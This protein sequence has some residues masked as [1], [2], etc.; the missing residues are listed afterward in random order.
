[1]IKKILLALF[2]TLIFAFP[3]N[4]VAR[5]NVDY[6]YIKDFQ[7]EIVVNKDS[8]ADVT[9]NIV[10][11]CG[12]A[13][14]HGIFRVLPTFQQLTESEKIQTPVTLKSITDFNDRPIKYSTSK[15]SPDGTITWKI[16]DANKTVS[17]VNNYRIKYHIKNAVRHNSNDFDE[18]YWNLSGNFWD[19][20]IDNF[21][22]TIIF[23]E[24]IT[25]ENSISTV[26]SG[27]FGDKNSLG[28]TY[29]WIEKN[30]LQVG[31]FGTMQ[32]GE[33]I[34]LS[35]TFPKDIISP[36]VPTFLEKY[37]SLFY[38]FIPI[39]V[40]LLIFKLWNK[41]GRDPK[42]SP[43]IAPEFEI[44]ENLVPIDM[45]LVYTDNVM[46]N[47]FLSASIVN[48][49][50]NGLIKIEKIDKHD[51]KL[52]KIDGEHIQSK[53]E[54]ELVSGLFSSKDVV[55]ISDLKNKFYTH[56]PKISEAG[57]T[58]LI[59]KGWL[60]KNSRS[61]QYTTAALGTGCFFLF[62][63]YLKPLVENLYL[64]SAVVI[65]GIILL[66]FSP[67]MKR[68]TLEGAKLEKRIQGFKLYMHTAERYRQRF[69][70]KENIFEKFL[71]YAIMFGITKEWIKKMKDI[72]GE[73]YFNSYHPVWFIGPNF[74]NFN[75][76]S[77]ASEISSMSS[78]MSST[79][80]SSPSSSGS[81]GG[82]FSG[83]GGGGGGGGGW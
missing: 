21:L 46:K 68:R 19:L 3:R 81:G 11:D 31:Y 45:G 5:E 18:F 4:S 55:Q 70:E 44:P 47:Q 30:K 15:S 2:L 32:I 37:G 57:K 10:A 62:L 53:S 35:T 23:P 76:D 22:A 16:G 83:G 59:S 50:V 41:I 40:F 67:F 65:S 56:I 78:N 74:S 17:G 7:T 14:K 48:L 34:T 66:I 25:K 36:Y 38:L 79:I 13:Q 82:G 61:S 20:E 80:S 27:E 33:G 60:V 52:T 42:I 73:N 49:A 77:L 54:E 24:A 26:Y 39:L 28:A 1:M 63:F 75:V 8:S 58:Y 43:T 6:W 29:N 72:Y 71:P 12:T 64:G 69:N 9:E 51:F